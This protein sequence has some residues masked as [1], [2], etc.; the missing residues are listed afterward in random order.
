MQ[1]PI[2]QLAKDLSLPPATVKRWALSEGFPLCL[3]DKMREKVA[4]V[5]GETI[6]R[7]AGLVC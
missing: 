1:T 5:K 6:R 7:A 2:S 3:S 4:Q